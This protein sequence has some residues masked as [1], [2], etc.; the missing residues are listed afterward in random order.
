MNSY[1]DLVRKNDLLVS[2]SFNGGELFETV[3]LFNELIYY[4]SEVVYVLYRVST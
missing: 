2:V 4:S 1:T 3:Y